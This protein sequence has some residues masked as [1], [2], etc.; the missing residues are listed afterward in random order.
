[1]PEFPVGLYDCDLAIAISNARPAQTG[2][3]YEAAVA[4][5]TWCVFGDGTIAWV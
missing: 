3:Q 4:L 1:M 2:L 5:G